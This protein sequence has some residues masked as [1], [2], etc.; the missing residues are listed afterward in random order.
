MPTSAR[1]STPRTLLLLAGSF[2]FAFCLQTVVHELG[3]FLAGLAAG[4]GEGRLMLHPFGDSRVVFGREPGLAGQVAV[5]LAGIA[6][7]LLLATGVSAL[8]WR[9]G[10]AGAVPLLLWGAIAYIGEGVG[11]AASL[12]AYATSRGPRV[13]EDA[14][15]LLRIG[16][17]AFLVWAAAALLV[18]AGLARLAALMPLAGVSA[19]SPFSR[20]LEAYLAALPLYFG[21]A[22]AYLAAIGPRAGGALPVR[23][24]QLA[25]SLVFALVLALLHRPLS[26]FL[27]RAGLGK[28]SAEPGRG[29]AA[30]A[31]LAGFLAVSA[32]FALS[33]AAG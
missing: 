7:D 33:S 18:A 21:V 19:E 1:P 9:R 17:P 2:A 25:L 29:A 5:G 30:A 32:L 22:A 15:Q 10:G 23:L 28:P 4:A 11:M 12:L 6:A 16:V 27:A 13:Y 14:T 3:H 24:G 20:R 26:G 8:A 31:G